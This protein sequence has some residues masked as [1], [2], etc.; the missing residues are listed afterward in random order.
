MTT[1][2]NGEP[3]DDWRPE[4]RCRVCHVCLPAMSIPANVFLGEN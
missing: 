2:D 1:H 4:C 3:M